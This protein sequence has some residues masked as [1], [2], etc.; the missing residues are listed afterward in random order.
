MKICQVVPC[1]PYQEHL[2]G[3]S[4]EKGYHVGGV[5]KH[6][7]YISK[8]LLELG[9]EVTIFTTKSPQHESLSEID[10]DINIY[11]VPIGISLYASSIPLST[12]KN[13]DVRE[14]DLTHAHT[15]TPAIADLAA[16]KNFIKRKPFILTYHN[17][18]GKEDI[19]GKIVSAVYNATLGTF[20]LAHADAII[21]TSKSYAKN[22]KQLK[23]YL[24]K[25]RII[26]NGVD[27]K[28]F[29]SELDS[30]KVKEK[31]K[32][33]QD[34]IVLFVGR[35]DYYKGCPYLIR[36]FADVIEEVPQAH[37]LFVGSGPLVG[38]LKKL[39][40]DSNIASKVTFAGFVS[41]KEL[42]YYYAACDVFV[43]PSISFYEGFGLVQLEAMAC[44]KPVVTTTI[45]GVKEV[46]DSEIASIH[47]R[48]KDEKALASAILKILQ[49]ED[50]AKNL[51]GNGRKLMIEKYSWGII[52]KT[53][54]CLYSEII[55]RI[56]KT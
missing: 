44:K 56:R 50:L 41:D 52:A 47:V 17:D 33:D 35:I 53:T 5:E 32:L 40:A 43:L 11:R 6:V 10:S 28:V 26:P 46:D 48:P 22:S 42:P 27:T 13:L 39:V 19:F 12:L 55:K 8:K 21:A 7:Y 54:E 2:E 38:E 30:I 36:A 37:L 29:H 23:K 51:G 16:L 34:K 1:F 18:I 3:K 20:L 24:S 25:V 9:N 4:V 45:P 14:Y 31:Y 49:D 15:P